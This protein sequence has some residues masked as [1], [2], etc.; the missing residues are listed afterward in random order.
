MVGEKTMPLPR[1]F[2]AMV[3]SE[4]A[5]QKFIREIKQRDLSDLPAGELLIEVK[6]S[7]LN[8]KTRCRHPAT[9]A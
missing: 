1:T 9:K 3:V 7:S 8:Y 6:Y 2:K 4:M 5:E